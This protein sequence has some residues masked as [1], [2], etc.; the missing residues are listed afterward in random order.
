MEEHKNLD[1]QEIKRLWQDE[2][3][4][5][6]FSGISNFKAALFTTFGEKISTKR[7]KS[8]LSDIPSYVARIKPRKRFDRR[9][10][11]VYWS[12]ATS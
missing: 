5:A 4:F 1:D 10:Y 8:I 3:F 2:N 11:D 12:T 9:P 7:L 6:S